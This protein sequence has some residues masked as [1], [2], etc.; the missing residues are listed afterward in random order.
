MTNWNTWV[1]KSLIFG[2]VVTSDIQSLTISTICFINKKQHGDNVHGV[3]FV[4]SNHP[5]FGKVCNLYLGGG[6]GRMVLGGEC[7]SGNAF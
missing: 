4:T 5:F 1:S 3:A 2:S 7:V 6:G